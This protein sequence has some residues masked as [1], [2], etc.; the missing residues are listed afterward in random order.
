MKFHRKLLPHTFGFAWYLMMWSIKL[1]PGYRSPPIATPSNTPFVA[2]EIML[3]SS[4]DIPPD[5]DTYAT[6]S[7]KEETKQNYVQVHSKQLTFHLYL[8]MNI[9]HNATG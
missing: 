4:L 6:L 5:R 9:M 7:D 3:F 8:S 1:V 2:F